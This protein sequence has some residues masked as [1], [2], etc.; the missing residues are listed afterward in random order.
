MS[1]FK[2]ELTPTVLAHLFLDW[3]KSVKIFG[4]SKIRFGQMI[5]NRYLSDGAS[6][7]N[8]FY[9]ESPENAFVDILEILEKEYAP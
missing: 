3:R 1:L 4:Y 7:P 8:I 9:N 5:C 6:V 2:P